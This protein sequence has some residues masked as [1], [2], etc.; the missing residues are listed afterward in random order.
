MGVKYSEQYRPDQLEP[1]WP[2]EI[3]KMVVVVLCTLALLVFLGILPGLLD[4]AGLHG[5][6]HHEEPANPRGATP[7]GIKPEWY[8]LAVY[9][10]LRLMPTQF[11]GISG[12]TLGVLSQG[13][14]VGVVAL[15]PF[16]YRKR[17]AVRPGWCYRLTV[18][19]A[20]AAFVGL[21]IWGGWKEDLV[22]GKERLVPVRQHVSEHPLFFIL[23]ACALAGFYWLIWRE[24]RVLRQVLDDPTPPPGHATPE[25][26]S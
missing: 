25:D 18:T 7:T 14:V 21:T 17:A 2:N 13:V 8:F 22:D 12:K 19:A 6:M 20:V 3:A 16:W 9:Q 5:W 23:V 10:Y 26:P 24:R 15:L 1:F 4:A 11:L